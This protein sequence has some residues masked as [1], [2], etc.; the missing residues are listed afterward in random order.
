[1]YRPGNSFTPPPD[2]AVLWRYISF[3]KF[4]SLLTRKALF[5][6]RADKLGDP[7]EGS[8]SQWNV[9]LSPTLNKGIPEEQIKLL[10]NHIKDQRRFVLV[11]CWHENEHESDAMWKLYS[12][13]GEGIAIKTDFPS[14]NESLVREDIVYIGMVNYVDYDMTFIPEND[15]AAP[16]L[17]KRQSFEHE[18][19][20]RAIIQ[21]HNVIGGEII[22]GGP[23]IDKIGTYH[24]VDIPT[25]V[26]E[27]IVPPYAEDWFLELVQTTAETFGLQ[28]PVI[29]S[30]LATPPIWT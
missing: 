15:T 6:A 24:E 20:V 14:R 30:S 16:F 12:G 3:T 2:N 28:S 22:V 7:Y 10:H 8:L 17:H 23:D 11:N 4:V 5:F 21:K 25:L 26:N 27:V 9:N 13:H 29:K 19:E 1:M 18:R